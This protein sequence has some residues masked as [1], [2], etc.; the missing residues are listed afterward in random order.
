MIGSSKGKIFLWTALIGFD[1]QLEAYGAMEYL[2]TLGFV[3][4]AV[5]LLVLNLDIVNMH[6][7]GMRTEKALP[8]S[9]CNYWSSPRNELRRIQQWTNYEVRG[10]CRELRK[11][12]VRSFLGICGDDAGEMAQED[13]HRLALGVS[14]R[15]DWLQS[16]PELRSCGAELGVKNLNV[17]K[18]FTDG[19]FYE[20]FLVEKLIPTLEDY[21]M[22][23]VHLA[24]EIMPQFGSA[25]TTDYSDD[26]LEQFVNYSG[27][28]LPEE[29]ARPINNYDKVGL[30]NRRVFI[31][32]F[33]RLDWLRF[34]AWRWEGFMR[35]VCDALHKVGKQV[36]A[37]SFWCT[38]AFEAFYRYGVD[39]KALFRA[40]LDYLLLEDQ[41]SSVFALGSIDRPYNMQKYNV[42]PLMVRAFAPEGE[43]L[44]FNAVKDSTEEFNI[45]AHLPGALEREIYCL[46]SS[47]L[48][49]EGGLRRSLNGFLVCLADGLTKNEWSWLRDRYEV[50]FDE[51]PQDSLSPLMV[52][53]DSHVYDFL[54]EYIETRRWSHF[55]QLYEFAGAGGQISSAVR[56]EDLDFASGA[57]FVPNIDVLPVSELLKIAS[58]K[59][60]PILCTSIVTK[61]FTMPDRKPQL[62]LEDRGVE[63][64][65]C[66]MGYDLGNINVASIIEELGQDDKSPDL[67]GTPKYAD[68]PSHFSHEMPYRKVSSGFVSACGRL[69]R[70][71]TR[72]P[73]DTERFDQVLPFAMADGRIRLLL[74]N[75]MKLQYY[76]PTLLSKKKRIKML[77]THSKFPAVPPKLITKDRQIVVQENNRSFAD[78]HVVGFIDKIPPHGASIVDVWFE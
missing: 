25:K 62:V 6:E 47:Y 16:H 42:M 77:K 46:P 17:L 45:L 37:N 11:R 55:K 14:N 64:R 71:L 7:D 72:T 31:W 33:Y 67:V 34:M 23:G 32:N 19:R 49:H 75:N 63:Y 38:D 70:S 68:E 52:F 9:N 12:D 54:P 73:I 21:E 1:K 39:Y 76:R 57:I 28:S 4:D 15:Q 8:L 56:I 29:I 43:I 74:G 18:R 58:Y 24:D 3:P 26:M 78:H 60:G 20:D 61:N 48:K 53:S 35:K 40:G 65:M 36:A 51:I 50:A 22:D 59:R 44:G 69:I 27:I 2:D 5:S 41:S 30:R 10:L 13:L 66:I